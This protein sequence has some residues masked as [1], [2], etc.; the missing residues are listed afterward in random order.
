MRDY[1]R[2]RVGPGYIKLPYERELPIELLK[3]L[4]RARVADYESTGAG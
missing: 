4:M 3:T 1:L 2:V